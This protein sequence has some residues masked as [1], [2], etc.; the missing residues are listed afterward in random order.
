MRGG[1]DHGGVGRVH[2][3]PGAGGLTHP[4]GEPEV[5]EVQ[6][7]DQ[8]SAHVLDAPADGGQAVGEGGPAL[9]ALPPGVDQPEAAAVEGERV[10]V[11]VAQWAQHRHR[12]RP[13]AVAQPLHGGERPAT[14]RPRAARFR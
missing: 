7:G 6:V 8:D 11:D 2:G 4:L 10:D 14:A 9:L 3:H 13:Q 12:D 5:V 1:G